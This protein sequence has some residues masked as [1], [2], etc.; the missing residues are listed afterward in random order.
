MKKLFLNQ[1]KCFITLTSTII[2]EY[3]IYLQNTF[4]ALHNDEYSGSLLACLTV[5]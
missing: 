5:N 1:I 2:C 4:L 3:K